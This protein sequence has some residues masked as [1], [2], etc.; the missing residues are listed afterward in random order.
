[1][2]K[3]CDS[4]GKHFY[5]DSYDVQD[6]AGAGKEEGYSIRCNFCGE[7][8]ILSIHENYMNESELVFLD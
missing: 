1:M 8:N 6:F 5:F 3:V 2:E 7:E 4:C